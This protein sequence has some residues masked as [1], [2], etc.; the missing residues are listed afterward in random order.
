MLRRKPSRDKLLVNP[1]TSSDISQLNIARIARGN[2]NSI[3]LDN[4]QPIMIDTE[5][6]NLVEWLA[7]QQGIS[8]EAALKKAIILA[9]YIQDL[10]MNQGGKL[11][12]QRRDNSLGEI[13]LK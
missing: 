8:P 13:I 7:R 12:V 3:A 11:L 9:A 5:S 2:E 10:T 6:V 1:S 4:N